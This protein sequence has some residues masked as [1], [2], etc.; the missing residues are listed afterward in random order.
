LVVGDKTAHSGASKSDIKEIMEINISDVD[1]QI[2]SP[3]P[4]ALE[5]KEGSRSTSDKLELHGKEADRA[6]AASVIDET[7]AAS[8]LPR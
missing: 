8:P 4:T 1:K 3:R 7:S 6:E 2:S 5:S